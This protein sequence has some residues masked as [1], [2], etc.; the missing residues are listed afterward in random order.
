MG[1]LGSAGLC[2][3][4]AVVDGL[5]VVGDGIQGAGFSHALRLVIN[6]DA[7]GGALA[8]EAELNGAL[9]QM[10]RGLEASG[11]EGEGVVGADVTVFFD[12]NYSGLR[13]LSPSPRPSPPGEREIVSERLESSPALAVAALLDGSRNAQSAEQRHFLPTRQMK[14]P[15]PGGEGRGEGGRL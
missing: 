6:D 10:P 4:G 14:L 7:Q 15:L 3:R 13:L 5:A 11:F 8:F 12:G 2:R 9:R 1:D